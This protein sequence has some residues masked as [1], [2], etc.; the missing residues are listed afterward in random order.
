MQDKDSYDEMNLYLD[1]KK[2]R[3]TLEVVP[4]SMV[5]ILS[6]KNLNRP[7]FNLH[8]LTIFTHDSYWDLIA[9][10]LSIFNKRNKDFNSIRK[11][12]ENNNLIYIR[13]HPSLKKIRL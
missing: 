11:T 3:I 10:I 2:M 9:C 1:K 6:N 4:K 5:R 7:N 8:G 12:L 13:L